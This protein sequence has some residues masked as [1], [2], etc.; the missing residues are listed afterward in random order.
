[1][2]K[3][4]YVEF[5]NFLSVGNSPVR[6]PLNGEHTTLIR[7]GNGAGKTTVLDGINYSLFSK[8]LRDVKLG[9]LV[10][11]VNK[12]KSLVK[13]NFSV[14]GVNYEVHRGQKPAIFQIFKDGDLIDQ[15]ASARDLQAK[16]E[17]EI[18]S[19]NFRTF[20]QVVVIASTGYTYFMELGAGERRTVVEQML[21]IE[22][23]GHM[24]TVLKDR[25]KEVKNKSIKLENNYSS[26][27]RS[28][29]EIKRLIEQVRRMG[30][31]EVNRIDS[32]I[33]GVDD[34]ITSLEIEVKNL[35]IEH[36]AEQGN[37]PEFDQV[38]ET[39]KHQHATGALNVIDGDIRQIGLRVRDHENTIRDAAGIKRTMARDVS[40]HNTTKSFYEDNDK[41]DRCHQPIDSDFK[42]RVVDEMNVKIGVCAEV[43]DQKTTVMNNTELEVG[44]LEEERARISSDIQ[45]HQQIIADVAAIVQ[46]VKKWQQGCDSIISKA[47]SVQQRIADQ[48][49]MKNKLVGDKSTAMTN[50]NQDTTDYHNQIEDFNVQ[51]ET[52][53]TTRAEI[54]EESELCKMAEEMLKDKGLKA[55][56]IRQFLPLINGTI[57]YYLEAMDANYS[58]VLDDQFNETIKS[59]FRD[60][61]SYGSFSNGQRMRINLALLLMW[62]KLAESK[63]TV[64]SNL[65]FMDEVLDGSLDKEGIDLLF[66]V[67]NTM[68]DNNIFVISHRP[69]IIERFD[70]VIEVQLQGNFSHYSGLD[71]ELIKTI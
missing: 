36:D 2:I 10:N 62:R 31:E 67:F 44:K 71:N 3:F 13:I 37:K 68:P 51:I 52:L 4:N 12:K 35:K 40:G 65:L 46:R 54:T 33:V 69:E 24:S 55:K 42:A 18:I 6:V 11:S 47:K 58:F 30:D 5:S 57:N 43:A 16:L 61:F 25:V 60:N 70:R 45:I 63:N 21:D 15:D 7:G 26:I 22:I 14:N 28:I 56:I 41:C 66:D 17:R 64:S 50:G 38:E 8:P 39:S 1:M 48:V 34:L 27:N 23:I 49:N 9:Q 19:T 53:I 59:R 29:E 20:N 32:S